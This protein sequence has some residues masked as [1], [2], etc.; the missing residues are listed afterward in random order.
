MTL[1]ALIVEV[2]VNT[3]AI[4][5]SAAQAVHENYADWY[6]SIYSDQELIDLTIE[7]L[8][9]PSALSTGEWGRVISVF[10][11]YTS[12]MQNAFYQWQD[13][14]LS[15]ELWQGWELISLNLVGTPGGERFWQE[16]SYVFGDSFREYVETEIMTMEPPPQAK[17]L[18]AFEI[19][20]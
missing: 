10:M 4:R 19:G 6:T 1:I 13:G 14:A 5:S 16:R 7:G 15:P 18:G 8:R 20:R 17:P 11:A 3:D 9:D 12:Y 2:R